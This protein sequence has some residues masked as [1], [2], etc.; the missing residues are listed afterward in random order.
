M[1]I[2]FYGTRDSIPVPGPEC[3]EFGGNTACVLVT[4]VDG[5]IGILDAGT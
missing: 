5:R 3:S 4:G 2:K 1:K